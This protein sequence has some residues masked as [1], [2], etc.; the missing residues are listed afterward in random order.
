M[1]NEGWE[2][3]KRENNQRVQFFRETRKVMVPRREGQDG[4]SEVSLV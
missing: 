4:L 2:V 3:D 1:E